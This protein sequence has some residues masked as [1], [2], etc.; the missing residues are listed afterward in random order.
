[1]NDNDNPCE[2]PLALVVDDDLSLRLSMEAALIK[3]GFHVIEAENGRMALDIVKSGRPD[4][5][6]LDVVMP[7]MDGFET[8]RAI[9]SLPEGE[10]TQ[11]LMVTGLDDTDSIELAFEAGATDFVSKPLNWSMLGYRAKYMLRAGEAFRELSRSRRQLAKTQELARLGNWEIDLSTGAFSCS[12]E[13]CR[14]LGLPA[15]HTPVTY[16]SFLSPIAEQDRE[17]VGAALDNAIDR[18]ENAVLNYRIVMPDGSRKHILNQAEI[19]PGEGGAAKLMLGV[20]QDVT[21]LKLAEE[22]IRQLAYFDGLTGLSNRMMFRD[23][24]YNA[25]VGATRS[26]ENFA[27]LFLDLD[28]FKRINDMLGHRIGD[29]LLKNVAGTLK[30][31]TRGTDSASRYTDDNSAPV[32]SRLGGDEFTILLPGIG[33]PQN[34]ATVARRLLNEIPVPAVLDGHEVTVTAS[35]GIS[36]F[37][38]D[39]TTAEALMKNAESAMVQAKKEGKNCYQFYTETLNIRSLERLCLEEDLGKALENGEFTLFYQPQIDI[40]SEKIVGAEALIRWIHPEK[41]LISPLK[42][43]PIAEETGM[44]ID[45]NRWV[46]R[47]ACRQSAERAQKGFAPIKVAVNLS[48]YKLSSQDI[49]TAID[50]SLRQANLSAEHLVVEITENVL[51]TEE[52]VT[53]LQQVKDLQVRIA[54][55]DFGTGYSSLSYLATFPVDIIKI[56]RAFVAGCTTEKNNL[57]IIKAIIAMGHSMGKRIVAEG[58]ETKE[59]LDLLRECGCDEAQGY[60]FKPP[61]P[62]DEFIQ[63]LPRA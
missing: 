44:I 22:E 18:K 31:C 23:R 12:A 14:L 58:I 8:C 60:Y 2:K 13:A 4:I 63:L 48:G 16:N 45:I 20:V 37:P 17:R 38:T 42:F 43:I 39:G 33:D 50:Q 15:A 34:A 26:K 36:I 41:G 54:L 24:L 9:R 29:L 28:R 1:M 51:M 49:T 10:H 35:I 57:I 56:D 55:D 19:L 25:I 46:L 53:T 52:A 32:L 11:I 7:G 3:A 21:R 61:V 6:L 27:V 47:T 5:V 30:R 59:Q 40:P 62:H